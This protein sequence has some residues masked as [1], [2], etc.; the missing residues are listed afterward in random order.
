MEENKVYC[1][2]CKDL[3]EDEDFDTVNVEP[4]CTDC[5]EHHTTTCE[6]CGNTV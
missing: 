2:N 3:I 4:V 6:R 5:I 1:S